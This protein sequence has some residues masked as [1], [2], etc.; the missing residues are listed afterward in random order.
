MARR[1]SGMSIQVLKNAVRR[2]VVVKRRGR[3]RCED[4]AEAGLPS[5]VQAPRCGADVQV[6]QGGKVRV[7][8]EIDDGV[9]FRAIMAEVGRAVAGAVLQKHGGRVN[10]A[11]R[12]LG[13][14]KWLWYRAQK[15]Q[16]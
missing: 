11:M 5:A 13:I 4:L 10:D 8:L 12:E 14:S 3:A 9:P 15:R 16:A 1:C 6:G 2:L 7:A